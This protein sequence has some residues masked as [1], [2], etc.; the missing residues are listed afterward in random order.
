MEPFFKRW[1]LVGLCLWAFAQPLSIAGTNISLAIILAGLLGSWAFTGTFPS[2][3]DPLEK[4]LWI[5]FL[6]AILASVFGG[7]LRQSLIPISK[8]GQMLCDFYIFSAAFALEGGAAVL[9]FWAAG[10]SLAALLGLG[11]FAIWRFALV[12]AEAFNALIAKSHFWSSIYAGNRAHGAIHP[13]TFGEIMGMA[14]LGSLAYRAQKRRTSGKAGFLSALV[15]LAAFSALALS[16]TRGAWVGFLVGALFLVILEFRAIWP[17]AL[18]AVALLVAQFFFSPRFARGNAFNPKEASFGDHL[19]L[20]KAAW[21]MFLDHPIL[22]VGSGRF[23]AFF[24][25]YHSLPFEGQATWG[26][27]HNL[28]LHQLA[29]RGLLG[30]AALALLLGT[31]MLQAWNICLRSR[32]F[33]S[34]WFLSWFFALLVMN[35][36]ESAFQVGMVWMP[37]LALYCWMRREKTYNLLSK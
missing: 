30:F 23:S 5:Y 16:G 8:D 29:E 2:L 27:A 24:G 21:R 4:P 15:S 12:R 32:S 6:I 34:L 17:E 1:I 35:L 7:N 19:S 3:R 22:G 33:L 28:Y 9:G 14:V 13:V 11:Q 18:A 31:M 20:W 26:N 37:T 10:F 25:R 36:T